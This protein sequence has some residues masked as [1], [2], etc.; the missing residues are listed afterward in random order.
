MAQSVTK[1][2]LIQLDDARTVAGFSHMKF[3]STADGEAELF[4]LC[5]DDVFQAPA[6][7]LPQC[8]Q[9]FMNSLGIG[10]DARISNSPGKGSVLS[11]TSHDA[12]GNTCTVRLNAL[13]GAVKDTA[14]QL[15]RQRVPMMGLHQHPQRPAEKSV[16]GMMSALATLAASATGHQATLQMCSK[17]MQTRARENSALQARLENWGGRASA[18]TPSVEIGECVFRKRVTVVTCRHGKRI[19]SWQSRA[20]EGSRWPYFDTVKWTRG[21][22]C[23]F[24]R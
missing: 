18:R 9:A 6:V 12:P 4:L 16:E 21:Y 14:L 2:V 17:L 20:F 22:T 1:G 23:S 7:P 15:F 24:W 5:C 10:M 11:L 13:H 19:A 8:K 3:N